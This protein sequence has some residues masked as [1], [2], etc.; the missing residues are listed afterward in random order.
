[1]TN[2]HL[3]PRTKE[4]VNAHLAEL[5][6]GLGISPGYAQYALLA[7]RMVA[8]AIQKRAPSERARERVRPFLTRLDVR[9]EALRRNAWRWFHGHIEE[10]PLYY[11]PE[12]YGEIEQLA[13]ELWA[14]TAEGQRCEEK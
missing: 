7:R 12:V 14:R 13:D 9:R 1:M 3:F 8:D 2:E 5:E 6:G 10:P 11:P 4:A